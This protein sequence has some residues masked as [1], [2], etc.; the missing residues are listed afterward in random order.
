MAM[1]GSCL[2][3]A[4]PALARG[5]EAMERLGSMGSDALPRRSGGRAAACEARLEQQRRVFIDP[6]GG[7]VALMTPSSKHERYAWGT[8]RLMD[9][10]DRAGIPV[11]ALGATR[12]RRPEDPENTGAEDACYYLGETADAGDRLTR[13]EAELEAFELHAALAGDRGRAE[14]RRRGQ[15]RLLCRL[16]VPEMWRLDISGNTR[17]AA[18]LDLQAPDGPAELSPP[19]CSLRQPRPL[20]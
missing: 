7:L 20:C 18:M 12:W 4:E 2:H 19:R 14:R 16:G 10:V 11:V 5:M 9:A 3:N 15:A 17:E 8:G 6:V 13:G 1:R